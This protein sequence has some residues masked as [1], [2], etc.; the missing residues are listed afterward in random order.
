VVF[1]V[2]LVVIIVSN[3]LIV[4]GVVDL[5]NV[6]VILVLGIV[7]YPNFGVVVKLL[8]KFVL[9]IVVGILI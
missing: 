8:I 9:D 7:E 6:V 2:A 3:F 1:K 4:V 5:I